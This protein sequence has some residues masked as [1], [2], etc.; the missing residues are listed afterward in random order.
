MSLG[1]YT[2]LIYSLKDIDLNAQTPVEVLHTILLGFVKYFWR[3][4]VSRQTC[5]GKDT[6]SQ[7]LSS[8][9]VSDL[10]LAALRGSSL[11]QHAGSLTGGDFK[12]IIQ[13]AQ[14][15]LQGMIPSEAYEAWTALGR[16]CNIVFRPRI[17]GDFELY[18]VRPFLFI[19]PERSSFYAE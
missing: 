17:S 10:Q 6:L 18:I 3:D 1:S 11:V 15:V 13:V 7:R 5:E 8:I 16:L 14:A 4:A 9:D 12:A 2:A 19:C